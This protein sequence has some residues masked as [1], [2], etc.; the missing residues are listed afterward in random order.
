[1]TTRRQ[2]LTGTS[3]LGVIA[4]SGKGSDTGL[5]PMAVRS[6]EP[7]KWVPEQTLNLDLFPCGIQVGDVTA[8][9]AFVSIQT[10]AVSIRWVLMEASAQEW[11][12]RSTSDSGL[13][14]SDGTIQFKLVD[15][16]SDTGYCLCAFDEES[17]D[18]SAVVRF[19]SGMSDSDWRVFTFGAASCL[20]GNRPW[21][22]FS[23]AAEEQLD[24]FLLLGDTVY[25]NARNYAVAWAD[26][27]SALKVQG[28]Q[29]LTQST[30]IIATWDDHELVNNFD[31]DLIEDAE[32]VHSNA[33]RAFTKALPMDIEQTGTMYRKV[34]HGAVCDVFVLDC[35]GERRSASGQYIS[36]EQMTWLKTELAASTARFKFIMNSVPI[37]DFSDLIGEVEAIDR[38]Q[39]FPEQRF[40]IL[41]HIEDNAIS[42][43]LWLSG[44]FHFGLVAKVSAEGSIGDS[45]M[46][47]LNGPTG[48]FLNIMGELMVTTDQYQDAV[49][50]W[51]YSRFECNPQTG[52]VAVSFIDDDGQVLL[53]R[54]LL[55]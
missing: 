24:F 46:E 12:E 13:E 9:K 40:E 28:F 25:T 3:T 10:T 17:G 54:V 33:W 23:R 35:R 45:M 55:L 48:S 31:W 43:V 49:A 47:V 52:E 15:L 39:G 11:I 21:K 2:F 41:S 32:T 5:E 20:G 14:V 26:W 51:T 29:E 38:W 53:E 50:A 30:S 18:R 1:M 27:K 6:A 19:R 44:D 36:P 42:G 37:I 34:S 16:L 4:C 22:T 8:Q 7:E